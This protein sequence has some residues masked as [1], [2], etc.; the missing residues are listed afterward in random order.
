MS[1]NESAQAVQLP[2][3]LLASSLLVLAA[4]FAWLKLPVVEQSASHEQM[5]DSKGSAWQYRHLT[6]GAMA[7]F[8][9]VG[10][11]LQSAAS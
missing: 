3:L 4:L 8:L 1:A 11:K 7:I 5:D 9:Y 6:L 2:Y 10:R